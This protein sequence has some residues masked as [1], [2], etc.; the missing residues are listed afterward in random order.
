MNALFMRHR[1]RRTRF[2]D[3]ADSKLSDSVPLLCRLL[4]HLLDILRYLRSTVE[5][6]R[7]DDFLKK[8]WMLVKIGLRDFSVFLKE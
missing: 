5:R 8:F 1:D 2:F 4:S 7:P 6:R 3:L